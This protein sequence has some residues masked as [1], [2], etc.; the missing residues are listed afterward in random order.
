M[1]PR[2]RLFATL[3]VLALAVAPLR[4]GLAADLAAHRA[5]YT[6]ALEA[7][8]GEVTA[9]TGDMSYEVQ[10][11]CDG[12]AVRQRLHMTITNRDGQDIEM[13]SDYVTWES[14]DGHRFRFHM[15]QLTDTAVTSQTE[16]EATT[17][18]EGGEAHYTLPAEDTKKLAPGTLLP[19]AHTAA[20][21]AAAQ[22]GKKFVGIPLFDGTSENGGQDTSITVLDWKPAGAE[23]GKWA[24]LLKLPS[25]HVH[26]A[27]FSGKAD[28]STPEYEVGMRYWDN[29]VGDDLRMDF[30]SF[31]MQGTMTE[32]TLL[33]HR[34]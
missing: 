19:M 32:F 13:V 2:H 27:F 14:K 31:V 16:G 22:A 8:K 11:A 24:D 1:R 12:W 21:I 3:T 9:A 15:K 23:G 25:T 34:C 18:P 10:D 33:P 6:L 7:P 28:A 30:G 29:G 5:V 20:I 26:V 4:A 17:G